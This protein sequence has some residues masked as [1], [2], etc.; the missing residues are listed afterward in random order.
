MDPDGTSAAER[1]A[2]VN[3]AEALLY[4]TAPRWADEAAVSYY[5]TPD[6]LDWVLQT[7]LPPEKRRQIAAE[8]SETYQGEASRGDRSGV[9][10]GRR[11]RVA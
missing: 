5:T 10:A 9:E 2:V 6:S 1:R 7:M 11:G 3:R 4:S 8:I